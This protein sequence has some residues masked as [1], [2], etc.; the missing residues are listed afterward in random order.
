MNDLIPVLSE[1]HSKIKENKSTI[2]ELRLRGIETIFAMLPKGTS[3][4]PD[5]DSFRAM[6]SE[7]NYY[8]NILDTNRP[9]FSFDYGDEIN[10]YLTNMRLRLD[11]LSEILNT[12]K[13]SRGFSLQ[14]IIEMMN[15]TVE[16]ARNNASIRD[17]TSD[18]NDENHRARL[19]AFTNIARIVGY[20]QKR[21]ILAGPDLDSNYQL[22]KPEL[23]EEKEQELSQAT[24]SQGPSSSGSL[25]TT[26]TTSTP[27]SP[28]SQ[29]QAQAGF[30][31][32]PST[33][34]TSKKGPRQPDGPHPS[35]VKAKP[36]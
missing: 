2:A 3:E 28:S 32:P 31:S 16:M 34:S 5:K 13:S 18:S 10:A 36:E 22:K 27:S 4:K 24:T 1:S 25:P 15:T 6:I 21:I 12:G 7:I 29:T 11:N 23:E 19:N 17:K 35:T 8:L 33:S 26:S 30:F 14:K 9:F 20:M